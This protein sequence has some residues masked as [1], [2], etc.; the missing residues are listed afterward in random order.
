MV[1][2]CVAFMV[3]S[4][5]SG[6]LVSKASRLAG[7]LAPVEVTG[8]APWA[9]AKQP[10]GRPRVV[11]AVLVSE[12]NEAAKLPGRGGAL[13]LFDLG[14]VHLGPGNAERGERCQELS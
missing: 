7:R 3:T 14:D 4:V 8:L 1:F 9:L 2:S 11:S 12:R 10:A 13:D 6:R 5:R